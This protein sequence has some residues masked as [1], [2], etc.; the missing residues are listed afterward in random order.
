MDLPIEEKT[1]KDNKVF[2]VADNSL[3][4]C[5]DEKI[6]IDIINEIAK[7][8]PVRVVFRDEAFEKDSDKINAYERLKKLSPKTEVKVI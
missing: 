5:L 1:I 4:A 2:Y 7:C 6:N 8:V 3:V